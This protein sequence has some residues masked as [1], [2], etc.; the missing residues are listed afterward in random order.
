MMTRLTVN[1]F[2]EHLHSILKQI[3]DDH[4][5]VSVAID[6]DR[7]VVVMAAEDYESLAETFYLTR[8]PANAECL[9]EGI[10]QYQEGQRK[11]IDV[12]TY[13]D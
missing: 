13:L 1:E 10:Q 11:V 8:N 4:D 12:K 3:S 6:Q 2:Q 9:R 7:K 5:P